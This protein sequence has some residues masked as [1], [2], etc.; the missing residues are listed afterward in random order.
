MTGAYPSDV[1]ACVESSASRFFA[2]SYKE[3]ETE[4]LAIQALVQQK[5]TKR[6]ALKALHLY[7]TKSERGILSDHDY[8][9]AQLFDLFGFMEKSKLEHLQRISS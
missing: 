8:S 4:Q 3:Q 9:V 2:K 7:F 6:L 1:I 5:L